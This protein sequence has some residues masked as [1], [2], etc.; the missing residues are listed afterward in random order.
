MSSLAHA[1]HFFTTALRHPTLIFRAGFVIAALPA[2]VCTAAAAPARQVE[3][4][5]EFNIPAGDAAATLRQLSA[6]AGVELLYST[7]TVAGV[8]TRPVQGRLSPPEALAQLLRDTPL[9]AQRHP[10][11]GG[12][13]IIPPKGTGGGTTAQPPRP[14]DNAASEAA[15]PSQKTPETT[16]KDPAPMK[17]RTMF[18][19]LAGW[20]AAGPALDAQTPSPEHGAANGTVTGYVKNT[21][22]DTILSSA[23]VVVETTSQRAVTGADGSYSLSLPPGRHTL[24]A[25][26]AGLHAVKSTIEL[27][28]RQTVVVN[29]DLTSEIYKL[30]AFVVRTVREQEAL[31]L[32]QQRFSS[33]PKTVVS[34]DAFGAPA[35][36][37]GELLQRVPGI[38]T[39]FREGELA[40]VYIRGMGA[41]FSRVAIDGEAAAATAGN[42]F[43]PTRSFNISEYATNHLAQVELI[44]A[45]TPDQDAD[46]IAGTI[47]LVTKRYFSRPASLVVNLALNGI[48][49]D[50]EGTPTR[51]EF[52][53]YG[54][55][56][57]SYNNSFD[58]A[59]GRK[60][61][62]AAVDVAWSRVL[63]VVEDAGP[64]RA[65]NLQT[66]YFTPTVGDPLAR[67]FSSDETGG[68]VEKLSANFGLDYKIRE[69][70]LAYLKLGFTRQ[71]R[72]DG[73]YTVRAMGAAAAPTAFAPGSTSENTVVL[74]ATNTLLDTRP[75]ASARQARKVDLTAGGEYRL[76]DDTTKLSLLGSYSSASSKNPYF[77]NVAAEVRGVGYQIDRRGGAM[78][79]PKLIQTAGPSWNDPA[80]Y[81]VTTLANTRTEGAPATNYVLRAD[82]EKKWPGTH[83]LSIK[84]G[85]KYVD[86]ITEDTRYYEQW[87][88]VGPDGILNSGDENLN[89]LK[90]QMI[91]L[92]QAAYG[93]F[94]ILPRATTKEGIAPSAF[95]KKTAAQA[96]N[97]LIGSS[98]RPTKI[99]EETTSTYAM[100]TVGTGQLRAV[101]GVRMER[102]EVTSH[103]WIRND[104]VAWGGNS[105][106]GTSVDPAVVAANIARAKRSYAERKR[107]NA[108]YS[109]LFPGIHLIW[110]PRDGMLLRAS[111]NK[112]VSRPS[113][114][115]TLPV[116]TVNDETRVVTVGNPD[117]KPYLSDNFEVSA[118]KYLEPVGLISVGVFQKNISRYF[119]TFSDII[120]PEG[121]DGT[122]TYAG[123][124]RRTS[125]NVGS[126]K[127]KGVEVSFQQ[128]FRKLP[129]AWSGLGGFANF[130]YLRTLG[131]FGTGVVTK[132]L[133][134]MTPR[135]LNAGLSYIGKGWQVRPLVN[136]Q[137]RTYKGVSG[138]ADYES[139]SRVRV[140]LKIEK[141]LGK[142]YS[143]ELAVFNLTNQP[144]ESLISLDG[145]RPFAQVWSGIA[146][147]LGVTG[148]F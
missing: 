74:P 53:R 103:A 116:G 47:N 138:N 111:Y 13:A 16:Q 15:Q 122:G 113:T 97:E 70:G 145:R 52:G 80:N 44:R 39:D 48:R 84:G 35:D 114:A 133:A 45:P 126:A 104:S 142:N 30:D 87:T 90:Y 140:D 6:Q 38:S 79:L 28:A 71:D 107:S 62:G 141:T 42:L 77:L 3:A 129:G 130:T 21:A 60:N 143:V 134:S 66:A 92:G 12:Y 94:P 41:E 98:A 19:V 121:T 110:E 93:P 8:R 86:R 17:S 102:T 124:E 24:T 91:R 46:A 106:G 27:A 100:A 40:D 115:A 10:A 82:L 51:S 137:D 57:L 131:D 112:S 72:D 144:D 139:A 73:R 69:A 32:Q 81:R 108:S 50:V 96:Y 117:L 18:A 135:T 88:Y 128:Q 1:G 9:Q 23:S 68:T 148:R 65:G 56:S 14:R 132:R 95:W 37:P 36:N 33:N 54:R 26:Y 120:G 64:R 4:A 119:T 22:T 20:L 99:E 11:T 76:F 63:R 101:A 89:S 5:R 105:I 136:W 43:S 59:G 123:Y 7:E 75:F 83:Q 49:R 34:A 78:Y 25:S 125:R 118:E 55:T 85:V 58:V 67:L 61:L 146:Y 31:S 147:N 29:F 109:D 2:I 127:L